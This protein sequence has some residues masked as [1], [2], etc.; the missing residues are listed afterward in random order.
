MACHCLKESCVQCVA[1]GP[2]K[3]CVWSSDV[4]LMLM[5]QLSTALNNDHYGH[6]KGL[7]VEF[8]LILL[9]YLSF[10]SLPPPFFPFFPSMCCLL[11]CQ[12]SILMALACICTYVLLMVSSSDLFLSVFFQH[13]SLLDHALLQYLVIWLCC[14]LLE[15]R[16]KEKKN[17]PLHLFKVHLL[18]PLCSVT[19]FLHLFLTPPPLSATLF[20]PSLPLSNFSGPTFICLSG[21][22]ISVWAPECALWITYRVACPLFPAVRCTLFISLIFMREGMHRPKTDWLY[23]V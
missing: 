19:F 3:L 13:A 2:N 1:I 15:K 5:L 21:S 6:H 22:R 7:H 16:K 12:S 8:S 9:H 10:Q 20:S 23:W 4:G 17:E 11:S 14:S 18:P